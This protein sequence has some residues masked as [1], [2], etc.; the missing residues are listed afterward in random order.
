MLSYLKRQFNI[1]HWPFLTSCSL[2]ALSS[3]LIVFQYSS[4]DTSREINLQNNAKVI[5]TQIEN[6]LD[7]TDSLISAVKYRYTSNL[8]N[9]KLS[10]EELSQQIKIELGYFPLKNID[11]TI[12]NEKGEIVLSTYIRAE[13][14]IKNKVSITGRDYFKASLA[15]TNDQIFFSKPFLSPV[16]HLWTIVA[17]KKIFINQ[18]PLGLVIV[19]IPTNSLN[20]FFNQLNLGKNGVI[21]FRDVDLVSI[22]RFPPA[23]MSSDG[24]GNLNLSTELRE[25][26]TKDPNAQNG[27]YYG[28]SKIDDTYRAFAFQRLQHSPFVLILGDSF[29]SKSLNQIFLSITL[30]VVTLLLSALSFIFTRRSYQDK[31]ELTKNILEQKDEL[32]YLYS[33]SATGYHAL[34]PEG[35]IIQIN[36]TELKWLGY[37]REEVVG[38]M[39]IIQIL[40][41]NSQK[42]F[43]NHFEPFKKDG[44]LNGLQMEFVRKDSTVFNVLITASAFYDTSGNFQYSR[45]ITIENTDQYQ[46]HLTLQKILSVSPVA[47]RVAALMNNELLFCNQAF[48]NL[49]QKNESEV[50]NIDVSNLY[51]DSSA[52]ESIR[53]R[54]MKGEVIVNELVHL[55]VPDKPEVEKVWALASYMVIDF[56]N[57]RSVLAWI[58]NVTELENAKNLAESHSQAKSKFLASMSHEIRTPLNGILGLA[59]AMWQEMEIPKYKSDLQRMIQTTQVLSTI[60]NDILDLSKIEAGKLILESRSFNLGDLLHSAINL[61]QSEA[62]NKGLQLEFKLNDLSEHIVQ[63]DDVRVR[64]IISNLL[65]NA[66]KFTHQGGIKVNA[67]ISVINSARIGLQLEVMDTGIGMSQES[68]PRMFY[69]FEQADSSTYRQYGGTGLGL[70]ISKHLISAM[71]GS[72]DVESEQGVGTTFKVSIEFNKSNQHKISLPIGSSTSARPLHIL[73]VDDVDLNREII[74]RGLAFDGHHFMQANNGEQAIELANKQIFDLILMDLNMPKMSGL[75][76]A[77]AIRTQGLNRH[78]HIIAITGYAYEKDILA[79]QEAGMNEHIAKPV[80]LTKLKESISALTLKDPRNNSNFA[81]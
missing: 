5:A 37:A 74:V 25:F 46:K 70:T 67:L 41:P 3:I 47:V 81:Q 26:V 66:I 27:I 44:F 60:L 59:Q 75:E 11:L 48:C 79:I 49:I 68:I 9:P 57:Q 78:T 22:T 8:Q 29:P 1:Y 53:Q 69:S 73:V 72:I 12:S 50:V 7:Q 71:N 80:N 33:N 2:I 13:E 28:L 36:D 14:L 6:I 62:A 45:V 23:P 21:G 16:S 34:D 51:V 35:L 38:K 64:Q 56:Q 15:L 32:D 18:Q 52:F 39:N 63:G 76:A 4:E 31:R 54:L 43:L 61:F 19:S 17:L 10:N 20:A 40:T 55:H 30:A 77:K 65:S 24:P 42:V 58:F